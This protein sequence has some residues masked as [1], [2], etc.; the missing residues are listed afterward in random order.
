MLTGAV[1]EPELTYRYVTGIENFSRFIRFDEND[2]L[3]N[4]N[5]IEYGVTQ[6]LYR[7]TAAGQ[8][9]E[10]LS[11]TIA[12]KHYFDPTFGG[13]IVPGTRNVF[14][15]LNSITPFAF[16]DGPRSWSPVVSDLKF[17]PGGRYD[18]EF[19]LDYD[20]QKNK[21]TTIGS[22][23]KVRPYRELFATL[24]H[25][26]V[27]SDPALQPL[28][29]QIRALVGY[30]QLNRK[31]F[32]ASAGFSYDITRQFLQNQ[33]AQVSYNGG[34]CGIA[35]E[36]RRLALVPIRTENQFRIALTIANLGTFGNLRREEKI[37]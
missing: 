1:I 28:S 32:N 14:Q 33:I 27:G 7:K 17:T 23:I 34:C 21:L 30:G 20:T 22:L 12:Q 3:T 37:F 16:A 5:E 36:Y 31:G 15:A 8:A 6:R 2:T 35:L 10:F 25:Y 18:A 29:N 13:A 26:R 9:E 4:T 11:W 24:A 19:L